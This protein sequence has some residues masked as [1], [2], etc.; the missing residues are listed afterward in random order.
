M[1]ADQMKKAVKD[2][3]REAREEAAVYG[4]QRLVRAYEE[5]HRDYDPA[6]VRRRRRNMT[7]EG[8]DD[9]AA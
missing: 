2:G 4:F 9:D 1:D 5:M 8:G 7:T 6:E 3:T